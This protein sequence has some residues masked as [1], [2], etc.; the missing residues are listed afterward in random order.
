VPG[1][2]ESLVVIKVLGTGCPKC[3]QL[4]HNAEQALKQLG[5]EGNVEKIEN[6]AEIAKFKVLFTPALVVDG[7]MKCA[8]RV[9]EVGEIVPWLADASA[10]ASG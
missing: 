10:K 3:K 9:P 7:A 6:V 2:E 5:V 8:G 1:K 4:T